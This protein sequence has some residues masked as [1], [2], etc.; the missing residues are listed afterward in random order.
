MEGKVSVYSWSALVSLLAVA[1]SVVSVTRVFVLEK[2][3][4]ELEIKCQS[5]ESLM[6][7]LREQQEQLLLLP[8]NPAV[9][10]DD[11]EQP[12]VQ[13]R[14]Q[15]RFRRDTSGQCLCPAG[16]PGEPGKRGKRGK[17]G[18]PGPPVSA[19][20]SFFHCPFAGLSLACL[21]AATLGSRLCRALLPAPAP[22]SRRASRV[23][24]FLLL[25]IT[26]SPSVSRRHSL[27]I[28]LPVP[29]LLSFA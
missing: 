20:R 7:L 8:A 29:T 22:H 1:L 18:D 25:S 16:P 17:K 6:S 4:Y 21:W 23:F 26:R 13:P 3:V 27:A 14:N 12:F 24:S 11:A 2:H 9:S 28:S 10:A 19:V 15:S 5:F